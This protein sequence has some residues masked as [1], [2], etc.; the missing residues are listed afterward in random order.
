MHTRKQ[1]LITSCTSYTS[2]MLSKTDKETQLNMAPLSI[3]L[4]CHDDKLIRQHTGLA[5]YKIF[6]CLHRYL[7]SVCQDDTCDLEFCSQDP[8]KKFKFLSSENQL[9]LVLYKCRTN[10]IEN[11]IANQ[12]HIG[13]GSVSTI[14]HFW[15]RRMYR[16]F[17]IIN[18]NA[19]LQQLSQTMPKEVKETYPNCRE[20]FDCTEIATQK[21]SDPIAQKLLWSNYKH[22]HTVKVQIGCTPSG[23]VSSVSNVY[24][25]GT[26]DK[27]LFELSNILEKFEA[28]EGIM[29]D[30]GYLINDLLQGTGI[31]LL[32][33]P[34]LTKGSQFTVS[35]TTEG[36]RIARHRGVVENVNA[37]IKDFKI[38]SHKIP[39]NMCPLVNELIFVCSFLSSFDKPYR[40]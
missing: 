14:F 10:T 1:P 3:E 8:N 35:E 32:R 7:M 38:L 6:S 26:S 24:G 18:T 22:G 39:I 23:V 27:Q 20:I 25:G 2:R 29:V 17:K 5:S 19:S 34:F 30:R 15:I 9:L 4:I 11:M 16:K 36:R 12:M 28:G 40:K 37:R 33:P 31:E 13:S 21:P